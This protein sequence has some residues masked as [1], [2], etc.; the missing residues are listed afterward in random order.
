MLETQTETRSV[1]AWNEMQRGLRALSDARSATGVSDT[2]ARLTAADS[3]FRLAR[4]ADRGW[5][6]PVVQRGWVA[7][8]RARHERGRVAA[9]FFESAIALADSVLADEPRNA[10]ALE[11]RGTARF[12]YY[13][14]NI[15]DNPAAWRRLLEGAKE[16]LESSVTIQPDNASAQLT[17]SVLYYHFDDVGSAVMAARRAY[18]TDSYLERADDVINRIFFGSLDQGDFAVADRWCLIGASRFPRN[19]RFVTCQLFLQVT[20]SKAP[21]VAQSW[22]LV[23]RLDT[24]GA[25]SFARLQARV[26][27]GGVLARAQLT[28][29]ARNV[30]RRTRQEVTA[31]VDAGQILALEAY[32]RT[33]AGDMDEAIDLLKRAVGA[34]PDH[35]FANTA[36]KY[37]WW[38]QLR[39]HPRWRELD[40]RR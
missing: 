18:E 31:E 20:P 1:A 19:P 28:D 12:R 5:S 22:R 38:E 29:S 36:G 21:D 40:T 17:L 34:N 9:P 27:V 16:D 25:T 15:T 37:W 33:L 24:L 8:E 30:W 14:T 13:E 4:E 23:A 6:A 11:L 3:L 39:L 32:T 7:F 10:K 35:D 26:L 2:L